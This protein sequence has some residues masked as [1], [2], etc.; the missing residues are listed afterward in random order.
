[1]QPPKQSSHSAT[2]TSPEATRSAGSLS[3]SME[4]TTRSLPIACTLFGRSVAM[5]PPEVPDQTT[6]AVTAPGTFRGAGYEKRSAAVNVSSGARCR[7]SPSIR[8]Q[9][10][11]G[12]ARAVWRSTGAGLHAAPMD[13]A[14]HHRAAPVSSTSATPTGSV[15]GSPGDQP[16]ARRVTFAAPRTF[17]PDHCGRPARSLPDERPL[18]GSPAAPGTA[19]AAPD[20]D[21]VPDRRPVRPDERPQAAKAPVPVWR[22]DGTRP[23][24]AEVRPAGPQR[25]RLPARRG[26]P[27]VLPGL[28]V[29][30][31][32]SSPRA[33]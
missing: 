2:T 12:P 25:D 30:R 27:S 7:T 31:E 14:R 20:D 22:W 33:G 4:Y 24:P 28:A 9:R 29:R 17:G 6:G 18:E 5:L 10:H 3:L 13:Q 8:R 19:A 11:P 1:M 26:R 23:G 16:A 32:A 15:R 21:R